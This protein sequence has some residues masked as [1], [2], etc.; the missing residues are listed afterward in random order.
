MRWWLSLKQMIRSI[1]DRRAAEES[2]DQELQFHLEHQIEQNIAAGMDPDEA[3][4]AAKREFAEVWTFSP[5]F[6][7]KSTHI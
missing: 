7:Q 3:R 6:P 4:Q 2:L 5:A 1:L